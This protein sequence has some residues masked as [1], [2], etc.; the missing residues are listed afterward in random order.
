MSL[1][2]TA[3]QIKTMQIRGA[4][5]IA[6]AAAEA[7]S[8]HA[9]S[10]DAPDIAAWKSEMQTAARVLLDTRPTAVSLPN[11]IHVVM[12]S[13]E[14]AKTIPEA[15]GAVKI[16]ASSFISS[17]RNAVAEIGKIGA[18]Y[19]RDGFVVLTHCNSQAA[20]ACLLT[21]K[22]DGRDFRVIATEVRPWWQ[23]HKTIQTLHDAGIPT[24]LI[25]DSAVRFFIKEVDLVIVG[26]DAIAVNGTVTNKIGTGQIA[27]VAHE[28]RV[29]FIVAAESY[30]F[31]PETIHGKETLVEERDPGEVLSP[32]IRARL[33]SVR[34]RNP[35]FDQTPPGYI[36]LI[37]TE[38][39]AIS[40]HM[41]YAIMRDHPGWQIQ[42]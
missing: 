31:A 5:T 36:D 21:A 7:L 33:P 24:D 37:L 3:D 42:G 14:N 30:K 29:R 41:A 40:P 34:V 6:R 22:E 4:G 17:S 38:F 20:L 16:A 32:G 39:G 25:V 12:Q 15:R 18:R 8:E 35:V 10:L 27:L 13:M 2:R 11:A 28:S 19:I 1:Y 23:G 26:A 9:K